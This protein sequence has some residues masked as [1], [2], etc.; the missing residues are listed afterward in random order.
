MG[1][2]ARA[3]AAHPLTLLLVAAA[4]IGAAWALV[5]PPWRSPDE[6]AHFGYV[7]TLAERGITPGRGPLPV[8]S[9][10]QYRSAGAA[11]ST[12]L[13]F[14]LPTQPE[15]SRRAYS[16]WRALGDRQGTRSDTGGSARDRE[17]PNSAR[18]N[19]PVYYALELPAYVAGSGTEIFGRLVLMRLWSVLALL[20]AAAATW[21]L[22]GELLGRRRDLQLVAAGCVALFPM[23]GAIAGS[24]NPDTLMLAEFATA[25]WL[26]VRTMRRGLEPAT[27]VALGLTAALAMLTKASGL[28]IVPG[29]VL[30]LVVGARRSGLAPGPALARLAAPALA[31]LVPVVA[32]VLYTRLSGRPAV[33][34]VSQLPGAPP[35]PPRPGLF[36]YL[37]Q[38]Y[39]PNLPGQ[40]PLPAGYP[41]LPLFDRWIVG[42][43][44]T[45]GYLEVRLPSPVYVAYVVGVAAAVAGALRALV[46]RGLTGRVPVIAFFAIT[47][48]AL[49][50]GLHLAEYG[51]LAR[52]AESI[53]QGRYLLV[54]LPLLG[55]VVATALS[56]GE[57]LRRIGVPAV[58]AALFVVNVLALAT[59]A[60]YFYA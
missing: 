58:L 20:G 51:V 1:R 7:Q 46:R 6:F 53:S 29:A 36:S 31:L 22:A 34:V 21:K 48:V 45:F 28:A 59:V 54:L 55:V 52:R 38:F 25:F 24:V 9:T 39:L 44:G 56:A 23:A 32:W 18:T 43:L 3:R 26:G 2:S 8:F 42:S 57:R 4:I 30:A 13:G 19:G 47:A 60:D 27:A 11:R 50:A 5:T 10:E 37:W 41:P 33:N 14:S 15:W 16:D 40:T 35:L 17:D 49:L 12:Y